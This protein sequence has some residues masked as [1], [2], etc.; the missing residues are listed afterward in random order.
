MS[1][2]RNL[3]KYVQSSYEGKAY[4]AYVPPPF[5]P[6]DLDLL[7]LQKNLDKANLALGQLNGA[8]D[9]L[10]NSDLF[11]YTYV[12]KEAVLSSQIEGTQSSLSD[13]LKA[14]N[15]GTAG[16]PLTADPAEA[17]CYVKA[18][19]YGLERLKN[20]PLSLRLLREIHKILMS[21]LRGSDKQPGVFR[22][23]QNWIGGTRPDVAR[24]VPPPPSKLMPC[25]DL[26]EKFLHNPDVPILI[27]IALA[28]VQFENIHP[29]LDGNGR[30]GRLLITFM[31]CTE[32]VLS[33]PL[34]YPSLY[35]KQHRQE[36]Y[37]RLQAV[38]TQGAWE[39]WIDFFLIGLIQSAQDSWQSIH[40][41]VQLFSRDSQKLQDSRRATKSMWAVYNHLQH[42]P[43]A[44][45]KNLSKKLQISNR[46][47]DRSLATLENLKIVSES[48]GKQRHRLFIYTD[49][50]EILN[51]DTDQ[52]YTALPPVK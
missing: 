16:V 37:D 26:F 45:A 14:E 34:L 7:R 1:K 12:R 20:L 35:L 5:P 10:E 24:F 40:N 22:R 28:H 38:R 9:F 4:K 36:Y 15:K 51:R 18:M 2:K 47:V 30:L 27:K 11:L 44:N 8:G 21:H 23:S 31:L 42:H 19:T 52:P 25:L 17:S 39:E 41:A 48:T 13:L 50:L 43:V 29:F 49:Y 33:R 32:K 3:G 46:T 6:Q